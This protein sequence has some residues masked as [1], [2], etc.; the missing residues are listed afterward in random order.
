M[1][2]M[3]AVV[4]AL[5]PAVALAFSARMTAASIACDRAHYVMHPGL[6]ADDGADGLTISWS[7]EGDRELK[8]LF[9]IDEGTPTIRSI[10]SGRASGGWTT[11][12]GNLTPEFRIVSGVRR[13][14]NQQLQPLNDLGVAITP[15]IV[16]KKK[17][18]AFWDAPLDLNP[19]AGRGRGGNPPPAAGI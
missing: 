4:L 9:T 13:M 16:Y 18:D 3:V 12:A 10:T 1:R 11:L 8:L 7:A 19:G 14:S 17:W 15:A 6:R 5:L 2:R